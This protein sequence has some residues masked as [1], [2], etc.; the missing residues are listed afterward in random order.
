MYYK[1]ETNC[2]NCFI[3][4]PEL[5]QEKEMKANLAVHL[6]IALGFDEHLFMKWQAG[7]NPSYTKKGTGRKHKEGKK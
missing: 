1:H 5:H 2:T 7:K 3:I 4:A 6:L